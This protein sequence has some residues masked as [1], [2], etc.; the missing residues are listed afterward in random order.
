MRLQSSQDVD[1]A[2]IH[3]R[4]EINRSDTSSIYEIE[5]HGATYVMKLFHDNGDPGYAKKGRD[6]N[7]FRC[8]LNAYQ[9]FHTHGVCQQGFVPLFHGYID[10]LD[11]SAFNPPLEHFI[12]DKCRPRAI[13]LEYLA[14]AERLNCVNYSEDRY[15]SAIDGIKAIHAA[16]VHHRDIYPKN[17]LITPNR[18]IWT[19][20]DV[21]T[22]FTEM[23]LIE[24]EYC[25]YETA[26]VV[27]FGEKL[28]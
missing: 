24:K 12:R 1:Y 16:F 14:N 6:L 22:T 23:G 8:E 19:D 5:L 4:R 25:D 13:I 28:V 17:I 15:R 3:I 11:P 26:L 7:R 21:A 18:T 27:N 2:E 10:R 9:N 20:F